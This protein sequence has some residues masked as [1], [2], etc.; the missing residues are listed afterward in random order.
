[1]TE[2]EIK[3]DRRVICRKQGPH[4]GKRGIVKDVFAGQAL[5]EFQETSILEPITYFELV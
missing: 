1:M 4:D 5:V 2:R 3:T